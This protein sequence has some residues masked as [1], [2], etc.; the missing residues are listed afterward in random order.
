MSTN[1]SKLMQLIATPDKLIAFVSEVFKRVD[2]D[3]SGFVDKHE[4]GSMLQ[5]IAFELGFDSPSSEDCF[6][7]VRMM[8]KNGDEKLSKG[9]FQFTIEQILKTLGEEILHS[10][11]ILPA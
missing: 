1:V 3:K 7:I 10:Q 6:D 2:K 11:K 5:M 4:V 9:E 8:D